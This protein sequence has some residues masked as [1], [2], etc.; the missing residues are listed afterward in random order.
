[1]HTVNIYNLQGYANGYTFVNSLICHVSYLDYDQVLF[2][3]FSITFWYSKD[4]Y[5]FIFIL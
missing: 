5:N 2:S 3:V 4:R 1:M